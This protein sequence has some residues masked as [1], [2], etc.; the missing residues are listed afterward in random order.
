MKVQES[1][2]IV[3]AGRAGWGGTSAWSWRA[4]CAQVAAF[5]V[6]AEGL[7]SL[8]R[9]AAGLPGK[10]FTYSVNVSKGGRGRAGR[11][12]GGG[13]TWAESPRWSTTPASSATACWFKVD[14]ATGKVREAAARQLAGGDRRRLDRPLPDDARGRGADGEK[15]V[16]GV[17]VNI[18]SVSRHGNRGSRTTRRPKAGLVADTKLWSLELARYGIRVGAIAPGF[19]RTPILDAMRPEVLEKTVAWSPL[20]RL[21][22]PRDPRRRAL[23]HRVRVLHRALPGHRRRAGA[24]APA[25]EQADVALFGFRS[26]CR[27]FV[28]RSC[29]KWQSLQAS[30]ASGAAGLRLTWSLGPEPE[31]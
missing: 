12:E 2:V 10:V 17:I 18:S 27:P 9:D 20:R 24:L 21:G 6:N 29:A 31:A 22:E 13:A 14:K 1:R 8:A 19:V 5:D 26:H 16:K 15:K 4:R 30:R 25:P 28:V 7:S 23:H 3:T 11:R